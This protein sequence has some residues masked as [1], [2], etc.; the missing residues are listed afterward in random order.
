M[1]IVSFQ[2]VSR[3]Y[4]NDDHEQQVLDH[5]NLNSE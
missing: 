1:N 5:V 4:R 2:D 3:V